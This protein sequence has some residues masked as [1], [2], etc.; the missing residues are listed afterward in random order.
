MTDEV[1]NSPID[2]EE[3]RAA[4]AGNQFSLCYQPK[5]DFG[6]LNLKGFEALIRWEHPTRGLILPDQFIPLA[7]ETGLIGQITQQVVDQ[8]FRWYKSTAGTHGHTLSINFSAKRL[9][10]ENFADWLLGVCRRAAMRPDAVILEVTESGMM[11]HRLSAHDMFTRLRTKGF[12]VA[13]DDFGIGTSSKLLLPRLPI[14]EI[15]IHKSFAMKATQSQE[16]RDFIKA[17]VDMGHSYKIAVSAGGV[18]DRE[19]LDFLRKIGCDYAYGFLISRPMS[20][21]QAAQWIVNRRQLTSSIL[22]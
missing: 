5:L 1:G 17:T 13:I 18:E 6:L 20:G 7:E 14:S 3:I 15:K 11:E 22:F 9:S 21:E 8:A 10:D 16:A 19:T 2:P 12:Q 4:L